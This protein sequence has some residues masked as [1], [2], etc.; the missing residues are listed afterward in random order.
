M[1]TI[2]VGFDGLV[3]AGKTTL[4]NKLA[5]H[6]NAPIIGEYKSYA[7]RNGTEFPPYP[8]VSREKAMEASIFFT[9]IEKQRIGDL[10]NFKSL[11]PQI[12][13]VDRTSLSCIAFDYSANH[14]TNFGTYDEAKKLWD[15]TK[16]IRP[17]LSFILDVSQENLKHRMFLN[18]DNFP[19]HISDKDFN[20]HIVNLF[21]EEL[22]KNPNM[23]KINANQKPEEVEADVVNAIMEYINK[24]T[25]K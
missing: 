19:P 1:N 17:D 8:P 12:I 23:V 15:D 14:F 4:I 22:K 10:D 18:N 16:I 21:N 9:E 5:K 11:N 3:R 6:F 2:V 20:S 25:T 7:T 13:L 24:N